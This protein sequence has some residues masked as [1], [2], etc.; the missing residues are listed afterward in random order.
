[1][2]GNNKAT[3][4]QVNLELVT[5]YHEEYLED[6]KASLDELAINVKSIGINLT[7]RFENNYDRFIVADNGCKITPGRGLDIFEKI[8]ER[9]SVADIDQTNRKCKACE[10]TYLKIWFKNNPKCDKP[11]S[12]SISTGRNKKYAYYHCFSPCDIRIKQED[13]HSWFHHFLRSIS[14]D[15]N[16]YETSRSSI[17]SSVKKIGIKDRTLSDYLNKFTRLG[18]VQ[19]VK[20]GVYKRR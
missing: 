5:W 7:F 11:L 12:G 6:F 8:E 18:L 2:L 14:L 4:D 17:L 16:A 9:F 15:E 13:A 3:E 1:M 10:M 19:K 20:R